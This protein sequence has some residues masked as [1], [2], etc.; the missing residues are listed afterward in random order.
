MKKLMK[1]IALKQPEWLARSAI[2]Q[3][4]PRTFSADGTIKSITAELEF[5]KSTGF[6]I[7]YLCPIFCEDDST[8]RSNWSMRQV[9]SETEN[10]KNPYRMNDYFSIDDEYGTMDDLKELVAKAH[11]FDMKVLLDLVYAHIG[12]NAPII[13]R[14]PEFVKQTPEGEMIYTGWNFPALD[15]RDNGLRE[16]LYCNMTYYIGVIDVDG[17][18]CDIGD[19]IPI[20]FWSEA[21]RRIQCIKK[22]AVLINEGDKYENLATAFDGSYCWLW[23]EALYKVFTGAEKPKY[24]AD[25]DEKAKETMPEGG[26]LLRDIDNHDT[27]TDWPERV[28]IAAGHDGTEQ[29]IVINYIIDGIPM[30][31]CGN[32]LACSAKLSMFANRFHMGKYEVSN[33][34]KNTDIALKR[35]NIIKRLNDFKAENDVL[36]FG[37][38]HWLDN[39]DSDNF[40]SFKRTYNGDV[41]LFIGNISNENRHVKIE[42]IPNDAK[43]IFEN[44]LDSYADG[45]FDFNGKGYVVLSYTGGI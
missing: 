30:I 40:I 7:V 37:K 15:Y 44:G 14:Y 32:E 10:P 29:I 21:K 16:Y 23:H 27:V 22:D 11:A 25:T 41:I 19:W 31:Y 39:S 1:N 12:P 13:K 9:K 26:L 3:V 18:R 42:K 5:L 8:D 28:E 2:Y 43:V 6:N 17:F 20:D 38:T 34:T 24:L 36:R 35:Q 4:N 45:E 33:R